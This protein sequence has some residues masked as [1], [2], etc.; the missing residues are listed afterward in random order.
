MSAISPN[1][2]S[3]ATGL[4]DSII[5]NE[6]SS[7]SFDTKQNYTYTERIKIYEKYRQNGKKNNNEKFDEAY[8][9]IEDFK[10]KF[11]DNIKKIY[12]KTNNSY[13][14][15]FIDIKLI[16]YQYI[17]H[18]YI[19]FLIEKRTKYFPNLSSEI[20][21]TINILLNI[22]VI[23]N[24][25]KDK[26]KQYSDLS[27]NIYTV[28]TS[29][30]AQKDEIKKILNFKKD[31]K[32]QIVSNQ[33]NKILNIIKE[34]IDKLPDINIKSIN[35]LLFI[36]IK[37]YFKCYN[38]R[39][40]LIIQI[41]SDR[42]II[43]EYTNELKKQT[44]Y[45][46]QYEFN[47]RLL[48]DFF[49][50]YLNNIY[51]QEYKY[52]VKKYDNL[53]DK[54]RIIKS[55]YN[56]IKTRIILNIEESIFAKILMYKLITGQY[57][58]LNLNKNS[59]YHIYI[60]KVKLYDRTKK[61]PNYNSYK[62]HIDKLKDIFQTNFNHLLF[63]IYNNYSKNVPISYE[64]AYN[65]F[66]SFLTR[67]REIYFPNL[68]S[69]VQETIN[70]L[71]DILLMAQLNKWSELIKILCGSTKVKKLSDNIEYIIKELPNF[72]DKLQG[73]INPVIQNY[74]KGLPLIQKPEYSKDE[75]N[76]IKKYIDIFN[77]RFD[78][79]IFIW[80]GDLLEMEIEDEIL[81]NS[82]TD[83]YKKNSNQENNILKDFI[84]YLYN[85]YKTLNI[86]QIIENY[87][88][89]LLVSADLFEYN[90]TLNLNKINR[91]STPN[92]KRIKDY[93]D[94][95]K[96]EEDEKNSK[97]KS[98]TDDKF[99]ELY[100]IYKKKYGDKDQ[101]GYYHIIIYQEIIDKNI[102]YFNLDPKAL[103]YKFLTLK[104]LKLGYF[105]DIENIINTIK[106][107]IINSF[108][109]TLDNL[110]KNHFLDKEKMNT[111]IDIITNQTVIKELDEN[112]IK[113]NDINNILDIIINKIYPNNSR[114]KTII[115]ENVLK[116][117]KNLYL[118]C[119][120]I[121]L[122][123][124]NIISPE[125]EYDDITIINIGYRLALA[126]EDNKKRVFQNNYIE[127]FTTKFPLTREKEKNSILY[128]PRYNRFLEIFLIKQCTM[129]LSLF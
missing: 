36:D 7:I 43:E 71:S 46:N 25:Y 60:N 18:K 110:I 8:K 88:K 81:K 90:G 77:L 80:G 116:Y 79:I 63:I 22:D 66:I 108:K 53:S 23:I 59:K 73:S 69:E 121:F 15:N 84:I 101:N 107:N 50:N 104:Y 26:T 16:T 72:K 67:E 57:F 42:N 94:K 126:Y 92:E 30:T 38:Y 4:I 58:Y 106:F 125:N 21:I 2:K 10:Q 120:H 3:L 119:L 6:I 19:N 11:E 70:I 76:D 118:E 20:Q 96:R 100:D 49:Y 117:Y 31:Q 111:F 97:S 61:F 28:L 74:V 32:D 14:R 27:L 5:T 128:H 33:N 113:K 9:L 89:E 114:I 41:W 123:F 52:L 109:I 115:K 93:L 17:Y 55:L 37:K 12:F 68:S 95:L 35:D 1:N 78:F 83:L 99:Q 85:T 124:K 45:K 62:K 48:S 24:L 102:L 51:K 87:R 86:N 44:R 112:I 91:Y 65:E 54:I 75:I 29:K 13:Y 40:N 47:I 129:I 98:I 82:I 105:G 64:N 34:Y 127:L 122:E 56:N 39:Y 103:S